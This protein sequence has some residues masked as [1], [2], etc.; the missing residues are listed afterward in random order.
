MCNDQRD[1]HIENLC[2]KSFKRSLLML[3]AFST[4]K[5]RDELQNYTKRDQRK[6]VML[7]IFNP[8]LTAHQIMDKSSVNS[9]A[10]VHTI[11]I[12]HRNN[13]NERISF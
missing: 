8:M 5:R 11:W 3:G 2:P 7:S 13:L 10:P 9:E 1:F 4:R 6:L 12:L